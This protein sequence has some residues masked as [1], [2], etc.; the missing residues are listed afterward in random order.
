MLFLIG[1]FSFNFII[2]ISAMAVSI[3]HFRRVRQYS[4]SSFQWLAK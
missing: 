2:F 3:F 1:S 4:F